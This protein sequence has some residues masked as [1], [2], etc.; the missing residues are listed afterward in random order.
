MVVGVQAAVSAAAAVLA[1]VQEGVAVRAEEEVLEAVRAV[2][3][4]W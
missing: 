1:A 4:E 2:T 3:A